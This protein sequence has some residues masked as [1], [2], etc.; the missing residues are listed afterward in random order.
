MTSVFS[1]FVCKHSISS[2]VHSSKRTTLSLH[3]MGVF[4]KTL[5]M[6]RIKMI[7]IVKNVE[8]I[9]QQVWIVICYVFATSRIIVYSFS[10]VGSSVI[11]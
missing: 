4:L 9:I 11:K 3:E 10:A 6:Q 1:S 8:Q 7:R 5:C 2:A